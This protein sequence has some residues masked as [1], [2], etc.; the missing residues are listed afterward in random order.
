M[1]GDR[2]MFLGY[3]DIGWGQSNVCGDRMT[4]VGNSAVFTGLTVC[5]YVQQD[6]H[7]LSDEFLFTCVLFSVDSSSINK[8]NVCKITIIFCFIL[9]LYQ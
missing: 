7:A 2:V 3:D 9:L 1:V 4:L 5:V 8:E 6:I